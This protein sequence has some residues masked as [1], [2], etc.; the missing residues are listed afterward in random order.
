M[1]TAGQ[2]V[3][4]IVNSSCD[5]FSPI[6]VAHSGPTVIYNCMN[7][8]FSDAFVA[9]AVLDAVAIV[10]LFVIFVWQDLL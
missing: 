5:E 1:F 3:Y 9:Y 6:T 8:Q 7:I 4:T 2:C 10:I